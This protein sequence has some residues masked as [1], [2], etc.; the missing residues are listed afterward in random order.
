MQ[1]Y[2]LKKKD[3]KLSGEIALASSVSVS[4]RNLLIRALKNSKLDVKSISGKDSDK[5]ID[6]SLRKGKVSLDVGEPLK[7]MR[8]LRA[9]FGILS[10]RLDCYGNSRDAQT[11]HWRCNR[12]A[13]PS[14]V[15]CEVS[16]SRGLSPVEN[17][18][19]RV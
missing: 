19:Q 17:H 4:K 2:T 14:G 1:T 18:W 7:G 12:Q 3:K 16:D 13:A 10:G 9:F 5:L 11:T 15:Q 8:F 6:K